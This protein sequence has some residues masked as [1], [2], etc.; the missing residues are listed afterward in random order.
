MRYALLALLLL[1][2]GAGEAIAFDCAKAQ[3]D[4]EKA[5]CADAKLKALDDAMSDAYRDSMARLGPREKEAL[6]LSQ[7]IWLDGRKNCGGDGQC[8][9]LRIS[10]RLRAL[11]P[12]AAS[13]PGGIELVAWF[14]AQK[15]DRARWKIDVSAFKFASP[16]HSR[17]LDA[18]LEKLMA[19]LP[20]G[21]IPEDEQMPEAP[22][23]EHFQDL[24]VNYLSRR[25]ISIE[26]SVYVYSGGAHGNYGSQFL[27]INLERDREV[28]F[29]DMFR[30]G[31]ERALIKACQDRIQAERAERNQ[32][33]GEGWDYRPVVIEK[34][35]NLQNWRFQADA[36][37]VYFAP[38]EVGS[39]AEGEY[40]CRLPLSFLRPFL[41]P[42]NAWIASP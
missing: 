14:F 40:E 26:D 27:N 41:Q 16:Q 33:D 25:F 23:Y 39:Y 30:K 5:I 21:P 11:R 28:T 38:Y 24:R 36:A 9:D 6:R 2:F 10:D 34:L 37:S 1:G 13:G 4:D 8:L 22:P 31:S 35:G 29:R 15:G 7:R 32:D 12:Q 3:R 17:T 19:E 42:Q 18:Y 20:L